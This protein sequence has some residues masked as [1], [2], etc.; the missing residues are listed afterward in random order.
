M[1]SHLKEWIREVKLYPNPDGTNGFWRMTIKVVK[2]HP[3]LLG[4]IE[5]MAYTLIACVESEY[6]AHGIKRGTLYLN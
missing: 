6:L 4:H 5:D 2:T 1:N 3:H